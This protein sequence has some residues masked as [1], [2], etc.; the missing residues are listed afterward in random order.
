MSVLLI[1]YLGSR[2]NSELSITR[3]LCVNEIIN[4]WGHN[5]WGQVQID[6]VDEES[7]HYCSYYD[8]P[9]SPAYNH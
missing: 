8:P 1:L 4:N 5:N 2:R 3:L 7:Y 6:S 9:F